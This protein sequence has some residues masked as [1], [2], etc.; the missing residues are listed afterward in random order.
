M[1]LKRKRDPM[2]T[3]SEKEAL[4]ELVGDHYDTLE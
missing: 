2:F 4:I 1:A 3:L